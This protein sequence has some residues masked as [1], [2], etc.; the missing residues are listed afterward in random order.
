MNEI[1]ARWDCTGLLENLDSEHADELASSLEKLSDYI[2]CCNDEDVHEDA[3]HAVFTIVSFIYLRI[4]GCTQSQSY[5][6]EEF[7][8]IHPVVFT[9]IYYDYYG[10]GEGYALRDLRTKLKSMPKTL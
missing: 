4:N 7:L 10:K 9:T 3:L 2:V 5:D 1:T 8:I 6:S